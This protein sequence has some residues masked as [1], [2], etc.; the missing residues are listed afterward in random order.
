MTRKSDAVAARV[1]RFAGGRFDPRYLGFF[2]SFNRQR[3]HAAHDVLEDLWLLDRRGPAGG[4]FKG[5]IQLAGAFVLLQKNRTR[6]ADTLFV[7]AEA[8]LRRYPRTFESLDLDAVRALIATWREALG[9]TGYSVNPLGA[10]EW[11]VLALPS[12]DDQPAPFDR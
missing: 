3:F 8:N 2:D 4:F 6:Q 11:P 7:L 5:L 1:A 10:M 12:D 9:R